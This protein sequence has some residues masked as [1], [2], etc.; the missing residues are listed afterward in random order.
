MADAN[1]TGKLDALRAAL[2]K[3]GTEEF[4]AIR[5]SALRRAETGDVSAIKAEGQA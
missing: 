4:N 5:E 2:L 1:E 3:E